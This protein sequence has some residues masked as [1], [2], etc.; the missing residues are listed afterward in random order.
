MLAIALAS[1]PDLLIADE[2]TTALD[3]TTQARVLEILR[4]L[5]RKRGMGILLISHDIGVIAELC[6]RVIVM[7]AGEVMERGAVEDV[8]TNPEHP[9]TEALLRC[10]TQTATP[11]ERLETVDGEVPELIGDDP[12]GGCPF[13]PRCDHATEA[14]EGDVPTRE[15]SAEERAETHEVA[16]V[17]PASERY[18]GSMNANGSSADDP[19]E[20]ET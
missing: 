6:D 1:E 5:N 3:T 15:L 14:C 8:L 9:Y 10:L 11:G 20:G 4:H 7:Y 16:C 2:P 17:V 12:P 18:T 13:A 19:R